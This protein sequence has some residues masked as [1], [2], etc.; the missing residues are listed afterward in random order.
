MISQKLSN[1]L[2]LK[3][4]KILREEAEISSE[5]GQ[6]VILRDF[7]LLQSKHNGPL[8]EDFYRLHGRYSVNWVNKLFRSFGTAVLVYQKK[9]R[10]CLKCGILI[11]KP[12]WLCEFC[13]HSNVGIEDYL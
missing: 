4:D 7:L 6:Q 13:R 8:I 11:L 12:D 3:Q 2:V 1:Q 10:C 9:L 5:R